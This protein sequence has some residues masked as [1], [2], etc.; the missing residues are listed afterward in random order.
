MLNSSKKLVDRIEGRLHWAPILET[1]VQ[2]VPAEI[3]ITR[4]TGDSSGDDTRRCTMSIDGMAAGTEPRQV[5]EEFRR[6]I[7]EV[8]GERFKEVTSTFRTLEDGPTTVKLKGQP[9]PTATFSIN[10]QLEGPL[11]DKS[12]ARQAAQPVSAQAGA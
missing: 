7:A 5:A 6:T 1:L 12:A 8:F 2:T 11:G 3:Q 9:A 10:I 4:L